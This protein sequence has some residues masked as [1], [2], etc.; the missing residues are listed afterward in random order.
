MQGKNYSRITEDWN[1]KILR[2]YLIKI[3][4]F[5]LLPERGE[6]IIFPRSTKLIKPGLETRDP[7]FQARALRILPLPVVSMSSFGSLS[8]K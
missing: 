4:H 8:S 7:D 5:I 2:H 1:W 3:L 6:K